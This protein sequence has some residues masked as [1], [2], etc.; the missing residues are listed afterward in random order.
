[1]LNLEIIFCI[2][3]LIFLGY[4]LIKNENTYKKRDLIMNAIFHLRVENNN[5]KVNY[6][7]MEDYLKT[8]FRLSD[9]GYKNIVSKEDFEILEPY[10]KKQGNRTIIL[11]GIKKENKT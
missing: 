10:I 8:L 3:A 4:M 2:I 7:N 11:S 6:C 5:A 9:W 1:M